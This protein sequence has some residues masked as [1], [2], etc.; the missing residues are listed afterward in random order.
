M[1]E[2]KF[3]KRNYRKHSDKN[4]KLIRK[5]LQ[6]C[7]AARSIVV[8]SEGEII[9]GNGVFGE[10]Q[11]LKMPIKVIETDGTE[12]VVVKRT[13]LKTG[14]EKRKKL[15]VLDNST[16]DTSEF[17][18]SLLTTDFDLEQL[19]D[20]GVDIKEKKETVDGDVPFTEELMEE[21]NYIVLYFDNSVDWLQAQTLFGDFIQ[22]KQ[23]LNSKDGYRK[24]GVGRVVR[25]ADFLKEITK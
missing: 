2:I 13:D 15:A 11:R 16:S 24:M 17:D 10:A 7:G 21:H 9:G 23:A 18:N 4:K 14:D 8:D 6:E 12:L 3:D 5:S 1:E 20:L 25:G 22:K 19:V